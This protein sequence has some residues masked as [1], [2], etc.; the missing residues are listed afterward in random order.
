M[1]LCGGIHVNSSA[2]IGGFT[3]TAESSVSA[4]VR[5]I[6]AI[7]GVGTAGLLD[8]KLKTEKAL[9]ER[10]KTAP[11]SL[12]ERVVKLQEDYKRLKK[13]G[14]DGGGTASLDYQKYLNSAE[15]VGEFS[16]VSGAFPGAEA[17]DLMALADQ[18]V[19]KGKVAVVLLADGGEKSVAV[20]AASAE[21]VKG[22]VDAGEMAKALSK[23]FKGGG[24][25]KKNMAQ[26]G[27]KEA[28]EP[29]GVFAIIKSLLT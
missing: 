1:E 10:L 19:A 24:G 2:K 26:F 17:K 15:T 4:G 11:D 21:A 14:G 20:I 8:A 27:F 6:E 22:G 28:A 29:A 5:R 7:T 12:V 25:G 9:A 18:L 23:E 3:L 16:F 13:Q